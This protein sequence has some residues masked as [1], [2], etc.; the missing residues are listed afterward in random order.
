[1]GKYSHKLLQIVVNWDENLEINAYKAL[2]FFLHRLLVRILAWMKTSD[3]PDEEF[4]IDLLDSRKP[5]CR[6]GSGRWFCI[7]FLYKISFDRQKG[8]MDSNVFH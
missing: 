7:S 6:L 2:S 8:Q 4:G 5:R 1:M 3:T